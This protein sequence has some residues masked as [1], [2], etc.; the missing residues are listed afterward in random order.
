MIHKE[1]KIEIGEDREIIDNKDQYYNRR[2]TVG[3]GGKSTLEN[4][5]RG[6]EY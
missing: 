6:A 1:I 3:G 4:Q 5:P 2:W